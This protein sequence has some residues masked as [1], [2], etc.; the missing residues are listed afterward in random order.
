MSRRHIDRLIVGFALLLVL[1]CTALILSPHLTRNSLSRAVLRD[2]ALDGQHRFVYVVQAGDCEGNLWFLDLLQRPALRQAFK[3]IGLLAGEK[4]DLP[5]VSQRIAEHVPGSPVRVITR[6]EAIALGTLGHTGTPY[7]FVIAPE[8]SV[9]LS[10]P[11]PA[12]PAG[13]LRMARM[14]ELLSQSRAGEGP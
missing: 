12:T 2:Q 1:L 10:G 3:P 4:D 14:L 6:A 13:Y 11:A 9:V 5:F 7:W 8:G